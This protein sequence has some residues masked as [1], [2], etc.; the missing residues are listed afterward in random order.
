MIQADLQLWE[1][2]PYPEEASKLREEYRAFRLKWLPTWA[3]RPP[4]W[5]MLIRV[6]VLLVLSPIR[7]NA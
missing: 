4:T 7:G 1:T 2:P 6:I 5:H 3:N